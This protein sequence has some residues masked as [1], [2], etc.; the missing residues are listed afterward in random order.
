VME[1]DRLKALIV[2][3]PLLPC[4]T[5]AQVVKEYTSV[6]LDTIIEEVRNSRHIQEVY[7]LDVPDWDAVNT[8]M[9]RQVTTSEVSTIDSSPNLTDTVDSE[10]FTAEGGFIRLM[11]AFRRNINRV[12]KSDLWE[13]SC[14]I[15]LVSKTRYF[16]LGQVMPYLFRLWFANIAGPLSLNPFLQGQRVPPNTIKTMQ[17]D[18]KLTEGFRHSTNVVW[19]TLLLR[20]LLNARPGQKRYKECPRMAEIEEPEFEADVTSDGD[21]PD[22]KGYKKYLEDV[23]NETWLKISKKTQRIMHGMCQLELMLG[24]IPLGDLNIRT[25]KMV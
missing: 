2:V 7:V 19:S 5:N 24:K 17:Y 1:A 20:I 18:R 6:C 25:D 3:L 10:R 16:L 12:L 21:V 14:R 8:W 9:A 4:P 11:E 22:E 23:A 13:C 15:F